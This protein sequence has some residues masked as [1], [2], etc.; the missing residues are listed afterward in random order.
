MKWP[1]KKQ[2]R[3]KFHMIMPDKIDE[4]MLAPCGM[5]CMV[6]SRHC[7]HKNPV[8]D[9]FRSALRSR[10]VLLPLPFRK[11]AISATVRRKEHYRNYFRQNYQKK[12]SFA[13]R[14]VPIIPARCR[15]LWK[16][17][18][19]SAMISICPQITKKS[20]AQ[21]RKNFCGCRKRNSPALSVKV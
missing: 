5:N 4:K 19:E 9:A 20:A 3:R 11:T 18:S 21:A 17:V 8:R 14:P 7:Y 1:C 15:K 6:C 16:S 10:A 12:Q 13:V 2:K